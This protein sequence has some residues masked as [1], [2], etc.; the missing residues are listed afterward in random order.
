MGQGGSRRWAKAGVKR[1]FANGPGDTD[2]R[3]NIHESE[4]G[5]AGSSSR[6]LTGFQQLEN[7]LKPRNHIAGFQELLPLV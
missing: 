6:L 5:P 1:R 3:R 7:L 2:A 4:S